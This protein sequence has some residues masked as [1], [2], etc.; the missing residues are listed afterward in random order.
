[1]VVKPEQ[2][3][4]RFGDLIRWK[5]PYAVFER[6]EISSPW[7][8]SELLFP[9]ENL[10]EPASHRAGVGAIDQMKIIAKCA[11]SGTPFVEHRSLPE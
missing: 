8:I 7:S 3:Q 6:I 2:Y 11:K 9:V 10:A 4:S 1:M 5:A